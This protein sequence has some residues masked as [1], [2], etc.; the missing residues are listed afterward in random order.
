M[1]RSKFVPS[2]TLITT[3]LLVSALLAGVPFATGSFD[4]LVGDSG[5]A[6]RVVRAVLQ[7]AAGLF[8]IATVVMVL[9]YEL[10]PES[11]DPRWVLRS[12]T[13]ALACLVAAWILAAVPGSWYAVS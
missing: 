1:S 11:I 5:A 3:S 10:D 2:T 9:K 12:S 4:P 13:G 8:C 7:L 6:I